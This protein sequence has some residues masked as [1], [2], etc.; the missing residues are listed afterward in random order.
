V[1]AY[2]DGGLTIWDKSNAV[3]WVELKGR[4]SDVTTV[5]FDAERLIADGTYSVVVIH[6]FNIPF[7]SLS[8]DDFSYDIEAEVEEEEEED[9]EDEEQDDELEDGYPSSTS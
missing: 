7:G 5:Q 1:A 4:S 3:V 9:G 2:R 8:E 6:D